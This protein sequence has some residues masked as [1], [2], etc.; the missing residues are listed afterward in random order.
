MGANLREVRRK[1]L[2]SVGPDESANTMSE[3]HTRRTFEMTLRLDRGDF[4]GLPYVRLRR[5]NGFWWT[6]RWLGL[7]ACIQ[8]VRRN[9]WREPGIE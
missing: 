3:Y 9:V 7:V 2:Y 6:F 5:Y 8:Y 4:E 1:E